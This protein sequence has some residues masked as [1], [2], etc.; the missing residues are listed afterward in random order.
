[1]SS[2]PLS[3][4]LTLICLILV[5]TLSCFPTCS[6]AAKKSS[7]KQRLA[8]S[9]D[10]EPIVAEDPPVDV[11]R[12]GGHQQRLRG[13]RAQSPSPERARHL[14]LNDNLKRRWGCGELSSVAM[15]SIAYDAKAQGATGIDDI[16]A[17]GSHGSHAKNLFRDLIK[18]FG[19]PKERSENRLDRNPFEVGS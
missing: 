10:E 19:A 18:L 15:Q 8:A 4:L 2:L 11:S 16:A 6:Y 3:R 1:M 12:R 17:A 13:A 9:S 14:P 7:K 5:F